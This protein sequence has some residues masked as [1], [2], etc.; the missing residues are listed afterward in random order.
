VQ[1]EIKVSARLLLLN[2]LAM[3]KFVRQAARL[4]SLPTM[5]EIDE[6]ESVTAGL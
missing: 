2:G 4:R 5:G 3:E 6:C 1:F